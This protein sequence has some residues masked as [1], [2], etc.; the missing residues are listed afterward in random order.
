MATD[1]KKERGKRQRRFTET[2]V[3]TLSEF[4]MIAKGDAVLIAVSGGADSVAL[5]R[6][7]VELRDQFSLRLAVAHL[8]HG[9]RGAA[10]GRDAVFVARFAESLG[11]PFHTEAA[12]VPAFQKTNRLSTEEAARRVRY[13][14]FERIASENRFDKIA[15]GHTADDNAESV[16]MHLLRGGGLRGLSGIP[17][18]REARYIRPLIRLHRADILEFLD[19]RG[20]CYVED[21]TNADLSFHRNRVRHELLPL[22]R[23]RY[24]SGIGEAL[25]RLADIC[26]D[27]A[28]WLGPM[29]AE[30][31]ERATLERSDRSI[32]LSIRA[33]GRFH[34]A[35]ARRVIRHAIEAVKGDLRRLTMRHT[36][37]VLTL[38]LDPG[39][40]GA[41][42]P[43]WI[44]LPDRI[45]LIRHGERLTF[46]KERAPLRML[47]PQEST[48]M[49]HP[50]EDSAYHYTIAEI[51]GIK[52]IFIRETGATIRLT[53]LPRSEDFDLSDAGQSVAFFDMDKI[54]FP[55][56]VR[57]F[58]AG[59]R[60]HPLGMAGRQKVKDFFINAK[61]PRHRRNAVP[62]LEARWEARWEAG[63]ESGGEIFWIAGHRIADFVRITDATQ[64]VLKA[65]LLLA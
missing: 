38:A 19:I 3:Q 46:R 59:D 47:P 56:V 17:P 55:I 39:P 48:L 49:N 32:A 31:C 35:L 57:P 62:V 23:E 30:A 13:D 61:I 43:R 51:D 40:Q 64:R 63:G 14:F 16:L 27:D 52:D 10:S 15:T 54:L 53:V 26:R 1:V 24:N 25:N 22:L 60:F 34:P 45:R 2:V 21:E 18:V 12:D 28:E 65:E 4:E 20:H 36:E 6:V 29:V 33:F 7:L 11:L 37:A 42:K 41:K 9:L 44:D 5:A 8:D 58:K 50:S